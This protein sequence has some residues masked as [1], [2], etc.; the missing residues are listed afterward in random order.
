MQF[1]GFVTF[2]GGHHSGVKVLALV[3]KWERESLVGKNRKDI[4]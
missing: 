2:E 4:S 1:L 3:W